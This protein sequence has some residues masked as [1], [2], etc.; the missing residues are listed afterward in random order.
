MGVFGAGDPAVI[1]PEER[2]PV[3]RGRVCATAK[4]SVVVAVDAM[5]LP[6]DPTVVHGPDACTRQQDRREETQKYRILKLT[7]GLSAVL[8]VS[9]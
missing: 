2:E 5:G 7:L 3:T 1:V 4:A 6:L 9:T 8:A